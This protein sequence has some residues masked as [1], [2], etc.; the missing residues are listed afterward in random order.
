[1]FDS[2]SSL[3][4]R[5]V[6]VDPKSF[7]QEILQDKGLSVPK[8]TTVE[9]AGKAHSP[10]FTVE[11]TVNGRLVGK[12]TGSRKVQAEIMAASE[13]IKLLREDQI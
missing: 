6:P 13:A 11:V 5:G 7:L 3:G 2:M 1:M 8:Y 12:G 10:E 4:S 9:S